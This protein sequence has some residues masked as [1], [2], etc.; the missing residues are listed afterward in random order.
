MGAVKRERL[1]PENRGTG[2]EITNQYR[3]ELSFVGWGG[4]IDP[5]SDQGGLGLS[6]FIASFDPLARGSEQTIGDSVISYYLVI[7]MHVGL[8][9]IYNSTG[10][11]A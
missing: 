4:I 10:S 8:T 3:L 7:T 1:D 5:F 6:F 11:S 9:D 2:D